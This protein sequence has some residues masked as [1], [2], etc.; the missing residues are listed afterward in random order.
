[1]NYCVLHFIN[2]EKSTDTIE[3]L[4]ASNVKKITL[5]GKKFHTHKSSFCKISTTNTASTA[6]HVQ[7]VSIFDLW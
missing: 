2:E 4:K 6:G 5:D 1:M 3:R 7:F